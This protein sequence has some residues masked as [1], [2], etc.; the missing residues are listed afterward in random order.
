MVPEACWAN[1]EFCNGEPSVASGW[2]FI[3]TY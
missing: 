2:H 3:S 1:G